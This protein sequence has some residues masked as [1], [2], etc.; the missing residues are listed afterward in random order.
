LERENC[1]KLFGFK[2]DAEA[3]RA[4]S[5]VEFRAADLGRLKVT[6]GP[7]GT[8]QVARGTPP[9]AVTTGN[10][11][12][13]NT[14]YNWFTFRVDAVNVATGAMQTFDYVAAANNELGTE[15][16]TADLAVLILL[17]EFRHT[18]L[19][20]NVPQEKTG[21]FKDYNLPIYEK[22]IKK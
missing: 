10:V 20:G 5:K 6:S 16:T 21:D 13:I 17:H 11:V 1:Y 15:M 22:C 14:S 2:S 12:T 8:V 18:R 3:Q 4:F 19:G 7:D 9:P